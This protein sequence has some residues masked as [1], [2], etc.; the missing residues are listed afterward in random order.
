MVLLKISTPLACLVNA[1]Y[2]VDFDKM[3]SMKQVISHSLESPAVGESRP[4]HQISDFRPPSS[5]QLG[6]HI[7]LSQEN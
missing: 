6:T 1:M 5:P 2:S 7:T 3:F 4:N